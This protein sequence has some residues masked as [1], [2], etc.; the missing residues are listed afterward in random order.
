MN[1]K[2]AEQKLRDVVRRKHFAWSTEE[3][4][5]GWLRLQTEK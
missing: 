2:E 4:Y 1:A 3:S 5:A